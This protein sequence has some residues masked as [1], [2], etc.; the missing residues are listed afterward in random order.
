MVQ[1]PV[2][3]FCPI[4]DTFIGASQNEF[5]EGTWPSVKILDERN[6]SCGFPTN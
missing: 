1:A 4:Q 6:A 2:R 5:F 3:E